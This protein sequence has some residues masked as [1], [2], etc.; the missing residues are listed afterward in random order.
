MKNGSNKANSTMQKQINRL[1][2]RCTELQ[3]SLEVRKNYV[4]ST[5]SFIQ[6]LLNDGRI[7]KEE[8]LPYYKRRNVTK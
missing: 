3:K 4:R 6:S 5:T 7:T 8:L 1:K 2:K